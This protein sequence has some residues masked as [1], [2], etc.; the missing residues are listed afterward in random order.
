MP[1]LIE[2]L[3]ILVAWALPIAVLVWFARSVN[4]IRDALRR[5]ERRLDALD[6]G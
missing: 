3:F 2:I 4:S 1:G 6:R 5:I